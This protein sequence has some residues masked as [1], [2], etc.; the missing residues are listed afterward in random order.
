MRSSRRTIARLAGVASLPELAA[1]GQRHRHILGVEEATGLRGAACPACLDE[2]D[3]DGSDHAIPRENASIWRV[4]CRRHRGRLIGLDGL[5]WEPSRGRLRLA[6]GV[7]GPEPGARRALPPPA[8]ALLACEAA[9]ERAM[10]GSSPGRRWRVRAPGRFLACA[11]ELAVPVLW[12][13][14]AGGPSFAQRFD[15]IGA[16]GRLSF[17]IGED[18]LADALP[19]LAS[20]P[21]RSRA[22]VVEAVG[23]LLMRPEAARVFAGRRDIATDGPDPVFTALIDHLGPRQHA[24]LALRAE[25]WPPEIGVP[26]QQAL[27]RHGATAQGPVYSDRTDRIVPRSRLGSVWETDVLI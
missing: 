10:A 16:Y 26:A 15:D 23:L 7:A 22:G 18:P 6:R 24:T 17:W 4:T 14:G 19:G 2:L 13:A 27:H 11:A 12:R 5:G 21:P 1:R 9:F 20:E 3:R 25:R 8:G